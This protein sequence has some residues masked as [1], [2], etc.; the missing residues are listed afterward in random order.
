[1]YRNKNDYAVNVIPEMKGG[2]GEF[3][4]EELVPKETLGHAGT[5]FVRGTLQPGHSVGN[6]VHEK[7]QEFC[8]FLQ[9]SGLVRDAESGEVRVTAGDTHICLP[10]T[11]HEIINDSNEPLVYLAFVMPP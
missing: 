3:I 1:M 8:Y 5:L 10:G 9:G 2:K 6:H 4:T 11:A 7:S